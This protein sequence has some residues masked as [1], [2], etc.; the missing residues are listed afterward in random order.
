MIDLAKLEQYRENNRIE[1][2]R[3]LGGLPKSI[4][5]TYSAFANTLGGLILLGVEEQPDKSL[6]PVNLPDPEAP[7]DLPA[8]M[9][10]I[11][12]PVAPD[13]AAVAQRIADQLLELPGHDLHLQAA[14]GKHDALHAVA[15]QHGSDGPGFR[16]HAFA[17]A[18]LPVDHG[19]II[20]NVMLFPGGRAVVV[21]QTHGPADER[22]RQ[23]Q[24]G[25]ASCRERV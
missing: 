4:W 25:R 3:A 15:H 1:A 19:R 10:Q 18:Q 8:L 20:E 24:I 16:Q 23:L 11:A 6:R 13:F 9:G 12:A 5:E 21:D 17:D 14:L 7:F 2:K 22:F